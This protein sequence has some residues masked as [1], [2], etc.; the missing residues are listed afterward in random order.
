MS[1]VIQNDDG[2]L[3]PEEFR[4]SAIQGDQAYNDGY[5]LGCMTDH[6]SPEQNAYFV[7]AYLRAQRLDPN[8]NE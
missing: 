4:A 2:T 1:L 7:R 5:S 3:I 6:L 8:K